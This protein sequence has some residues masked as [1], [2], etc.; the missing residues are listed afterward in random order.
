MTTALARGPARSEPERRDQARADPV[1][2][3]GADDAFLMIDGS[4]DPNTTPAYREAVSALYNVAYALKFALN[5]AGQPDHRVPPWKGCGGRRTWP[6][7][8]SSAKRTGAGR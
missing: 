3:R 7:S 4:R 2:S 1:L 5:K 6:S 8:P